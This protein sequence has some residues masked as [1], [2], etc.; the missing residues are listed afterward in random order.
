MAKISILIV[1]LMLVVSCAKKSDDSVKVEK[2]R[3]EYKKII[4]LAPSITETLFLLGAGERVVGV[5]T[6]SNYPEKAKTITKIGSLFDT[7]YELMVAIKPD[8]VFLLPSSIKAK[9]NLN[10][11]G[12][13]TCV[14]SQRN[15]AEIISSFDVAGKKLG[16]TKRSDFLIDSLESEIKKVEK[17]IAAGSETGKKQKMLISVG[18]DYSADINSIY[19]GGNGIFFDDII[20][21]LGYENAVDTDIAYPKISLEGIL[22][23]NPDVIVDLIPELYEQKYSEDELLKRWKKLITVKAAKNNKVI[24]EGGRYVS[25]PGPRIIGLIGKIAEKL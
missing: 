25:I 20:S 6:Y 21:I 2:N 3:K 11:L 10:R 18:R 7:N 17:L 23:I 22:K 4:S 8:L 19:A 14:L 9:E 1:L 13:E 5:S 16:L 24:I 15:I 12:I